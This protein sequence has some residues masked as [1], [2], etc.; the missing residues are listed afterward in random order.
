MNEF[1]QMQNPMTETTLSEKLKAFK[2][3]RLTKEVKRKVTTKVQAPKEQV[4]KRVTKKME[5]NDGSD[6]I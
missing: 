3:Q 2:K 5:D 1:N 4:L 6:I